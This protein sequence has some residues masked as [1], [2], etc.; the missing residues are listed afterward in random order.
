MNFGFLLFPDVEELDFTGPWEMIG[1]WS[2]HFG[3]PERRFTV[4]SWN[5][6]D[7]KNAKE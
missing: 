2:A 6:E 4:L 5:R 3:G 7:T 1:M